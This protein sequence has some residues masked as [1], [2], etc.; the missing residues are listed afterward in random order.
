MSAPATTEI[1]AALALARIPLTAA[2]PFR[3][4]VDMPD[5]SLFDMPPGGLRAAMRERDPETE[6]IIDGFAGGG[7]TSEGVR[8]ALGRSPDEALNHDPEAVSMHSVNHPGA[9]HWCQNIW[10]AEPSAVAD[11]RPIGLAW[12]SAAC[13]HFSKARNGKPLDRSIRDLAWV[14]VAYARLPF[15]LRPRVILVENVE[16]F[17]SWGPIDDDGRRIKE[18]SGETFEKWVRELRRLGYV[19]EWWE[20]RACDFGAP[21]IRKRL[22]V[23]ARCDGL[24]IIRPTPTRGAPDS[25]EVRSGERRPWRAAAEIIDWSIPTHSIFL[26]REE[27]RNVGVHRPLADTTLRR[28]AAGLRR[29]VFD[30]PNPFLVPIT[31]TSG[32]AERSRNTCLPLNAITTAKGG[33]FALA[34]PHVSLFRSSSVGHDGREPTRTHRRPHRSAVH[35]IGR[36]RPR[37]PHGNGNGGR[38]RQIGPHHRV[39]RATQRRSRRRREP[40]QDRR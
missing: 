28:I 32:G 30:S 17:T 23:A 14:V 12:F 9:R 37:R 39:Y 15:H 11:G 38:R 8:M 33:E 21:T 6:I 27:A 35:I 5:G 18:R 29:Y 16:E 19:V 3:R 10:Q 13:T 24:P 7:G 31:H 26:T 22:C 40:R 36:T 25:P 2:T 20:S 4:G 34:A 1:I